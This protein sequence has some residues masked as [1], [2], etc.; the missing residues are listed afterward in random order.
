MSTKTQ[1]ASIKAHIAIIKLLKHLSEGLYEGWELEF[2][3][4]ELKL[5]FADS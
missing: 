5:G 4:L 1:Y 3:L 2:R